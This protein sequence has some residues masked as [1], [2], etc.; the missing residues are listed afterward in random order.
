MKKPV[1]VVVVVRIILP[2]AKFHAESFEYFD[3]ISFFQSLSGKFRR[4]GMSWFPWK[5]L[6]L[7]LLIGTAAIIRADIER[8]ED[9]QRSNI[10]QFLQDIG[11]FDRAFY[12]SKVCSRS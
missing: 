3:C 8:H 1:D 6:S 4:A 2:R 7:L 10:G 5:T 12:V 11:Q 9:L